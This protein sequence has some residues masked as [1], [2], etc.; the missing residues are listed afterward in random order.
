ME[1]AALV[2][3][4]EQIVQFYEDAIPVAQ[5]EAG[6]LFVPLRP[7][8][9]YLG[10]D[11]SA[12]RRR[13]ARDPVLAGQAR[14]VLI[15]AADGKR[16]SMLCLPLHLLPGWLFG[17]QPNRVRPE[18]TEKINRYRLECFRALW[19]AFKQEIMPAAPPPA[20]LNPAEQALLLAEAVASLA[21]QHLDLEQR[22]T[23]MA[24]YLRPFVAQTR[25]QLA[26][27]EERI[28][29][30]ELRLSSG[31]T[32][33]EDQAAELQQNVKQVAMALH[34]HTGQQVS[35]AFQLIWGELYKRY[36]VG[37]YRNLPAAQYADVLL[38]L[39]TWYTELSHGQD[40][41]SN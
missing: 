19:D 37:A 25:G 15:T 11:A 40:R 9:D 41:H 1:N 22:Q 5:L 32:I 31:A 35:T 3:V 21:R 2:P 23:T 29:A 10:L 24:D 20:D 6:D 30:L 4:K 27:H 34:Q 36:R 13:V 12:A 7:L 28:G 26:A 39:Q 17:V 8:T 14:D 16:Y 38:W 33:S 18:L